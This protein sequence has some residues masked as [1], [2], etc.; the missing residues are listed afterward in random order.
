LLEMRKTGPR[1]AVQLHL[2]ALM[3]QSR[4]WCALQSWQ[5]RLQNCS[6]RCKFVVTPRTARQTM[7][8]SDAARF[9]CRVAHTN[10]ASAPWSNVAP[11]PCLSTTTEETKCA[12]LQHHVSWVWPR[13]VVPEWQTLTFICSSL[14]STRGLALSAHWRTL[15]RVLSKRMSTIAPSLDT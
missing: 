4:L 3:Q 2:T 7:P 9:G 12:H 8:S 5:R 6:L 11:R 1:K 14:H 13:G 10:V 15:Q